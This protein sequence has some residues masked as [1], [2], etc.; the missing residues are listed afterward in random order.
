MRSKF[1]KIVLLAALAFAAVFTT[2]CASRPG[3]AMGLHDS[4]AN[5]MQQYGENDGEVLNLYN[6][7]IDEYKKYIA[8]N[9]ESAGE[10]Y[11]YLGRILYTGPRSLRNYDEAFKDLKTALEIHEKG[12]NNNFIPL[13]YNEIGTVQYRLGDYSSAFSNFKKA[14]EL[15][16]QLAGDE[17]QLYWLGLG[18]EQDLPK[19]MELYK[20]AA[21]GGRDLWANIYGLDYQI[22]EYGKGNFDNKGMNLYKDYLHAKSMGEPKDVWM[23]ILTQSADLGWPPSQVDL[24]ITY[25]D[26]KE[27]DKG[28]PYLQKAIATDFVPAFFHIGYVYHVGLNNTRVDYNEAQKWYEKAAVEGLP[29]AQ[30]NLGALYFNNNIMAKQGFS[31]QEL[32]YYWWNAAAEQGYSPAVYNRNLVASYRAPESKFETAIHILN[33]VSTIMNNSAKIYNSLNKSKMHS[34]V[35]PGNRSKQSAG[36]DDTTQPSQ[37][38]TEKAICGDY[39]SFKNMDH[40]YDGYKDRLLDMKT[41][42]KKYNDSD[43]RNCQSSMRDIREKWNAHG[44]GNKIY[45]SDL[46]DWSGGK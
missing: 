27:F 38:K 44:C 4:A 41:Y 24:W 32:A 43:R 45:K 46:E 33:S 10:A 40:A 30:S 42:P 36:T 1:T 15:S 2:S 19:A 26:D 21:L 35:P 31:N 8:E 39:I 25:R 5:R 12:K 29:I 6:Q 37:V 20:K 7:A 16:S 18:V 17:A 14:S 22:K 9:P 13:C 28:M 34:Y 11:Q 3:K 23:S